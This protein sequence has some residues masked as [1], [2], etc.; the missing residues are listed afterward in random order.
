MGDVT[1]KDDP[2]FLCV[3]P[4]YRRTLRRYVS[5]FASGAYSSCGQQPRT[6]L[7]RA[8]YSRDRDGSMAAAAV[9]KSPSHSVTQSLSQPVTQSFSHSVTESLGCSISSFWRHSPACFTQRDGERENA[10][11]TFTDG[12]TERVLY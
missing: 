7:Q 1:L 12:S 3:S 8:G 9:S 10:R 6:L 5:F 2:M 4:A 11:N